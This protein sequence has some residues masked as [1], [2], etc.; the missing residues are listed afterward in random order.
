MQPLYAYQT[1]LINSFELFEMSFHCRVSYR[2]RV[3]ENATKKGLIRQS[4][5][6]MKLLKA[7]LLHRHALSKKNHLSWIIPRYLRQ[8]NFEIITPLEIIWGIS[9]CILILFEN[10]TNEVF[11]VLSFFNFSK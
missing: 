5:Y 10:V 7:F 1:V 3:Q 9:L 11:V 6:K 2:Y 8:P 4:G